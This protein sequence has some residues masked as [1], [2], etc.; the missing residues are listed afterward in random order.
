M[1][2]ISRWGTFFIRTSTFD[3]RQATWR[4]LHKDESDFFC[5]MPDVYEPNSLWQGTSQMINVLENVR[6]GVNFEDCGLRGRKGGEI[7]EWTIQNS[8]FV[9]F[10]APSQS[11]ESRGWRVLCYPRLQDSTGLSNR[12]DTHTSLFVGWP[13]TAEMPWNTAASR[14]FVHSR[15]RRFYVS[16]EIFDMLF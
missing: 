15:H 2:S 16:Q 10:Q 12:S 9:S 4:R 7:A 8:I 11:S 5:Q 3:A 14:G 13:P 6:R 1:V